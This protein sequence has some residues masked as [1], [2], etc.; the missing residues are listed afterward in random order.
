MGI[1]REG[2]DGRR[3][4]DGGLAS[5]SRRQDSGIR[6][7]PGSEEAVLNQPARKQY[8]RFSKPPLSLSLSPLVREMDFRARWGI[9]PTTTAFF[10]SFFF[11]FFTSFYPSIDR[12]I[13]R[14]S[15]CQ[16]ERERMN[17]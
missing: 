17:E 7:N 10:L 16:P 5:R 8:R 14:I 11:T 9:E 1:G 4:I 3:G 13:Y 2:W 12:S 6:R 15:R